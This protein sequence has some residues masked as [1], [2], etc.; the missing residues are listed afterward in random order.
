[1]GRIGQLPSAYPRG[2]GIGLWPEESV[3]AQ[4][5][6]LDQVHALTPDSVWWGGGSSLWGEVHG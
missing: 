3:P 1:M 6:P 2:R 4:D 5:S